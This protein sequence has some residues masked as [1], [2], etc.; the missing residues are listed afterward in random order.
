VTPKEQEHLLGEL[1]QRVDRLRVLYDQYFLG[2]EK[3]EPSIPRKDVERRFAILRKEQIRNTALRFRFNVCNQKYNTYA[4]YWTRICRQIEE[5]TFKRHLQKARKIMEAGGPNKRE[6]DLSIDIEMDDFDDMDVDAL[7]AEVDASTSTS[8]RQ[9]GEHDT[10]PPGT[11]SDKPHVFRAANRVFAPTPGTAFVV[12]KRQREVIDDDSP[13]SSHPMDIPLGPSAA[14]TA[15]GGRAPGPSSGTLPG[16]PK[17]LVRRKD[18]TVGPLDSGRQSS[19]LGPASSQNLSAAAP[20][21]SQRTPPA[22]APQAPAP[23]PST[24][25]VALPAMPGSGPRIQPISAPRVAGQP[26]PSTRDIPPAP[27]STP[28]V[29]LPAMPGRTPAPGAAASSGRLPAVAPGPA[30]GRIPPGPSQGRIPLPSSPGPAPSQRMPVAAPPP[31]QSSGRLPL[32][33]PSTPRAP[34]PSDPGDSEG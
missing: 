7:L 30:A 33:P 34:A 6:V 32:P 8:S 22:S 31:R 17:K 29:V 1:E 25:R 12:T 11:P 21:S 9:G 26:P 19:P 2:F 18:G 20:P 14:A 3:L 27:Q 23:A 10:V 28:K 5:G 13:P 24:P 16:A 4:M 15:L